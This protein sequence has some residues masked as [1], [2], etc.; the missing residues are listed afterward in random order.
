MGL[1][2]TLTMLSLVSTDKE[3]QDREEDRDIDEAKYSKGGTRIVCPGSLL[4]QW[5]GRS[6]RK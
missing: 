2:K 1:E 5:E 4:K 3:N 6:I